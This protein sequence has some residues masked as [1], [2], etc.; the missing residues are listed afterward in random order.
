[1]AFV[2]K[3]KYMGVWIHKNLRWDTHIYGITTK[4]YN[5]FGLAKHTL[6]NAP[7]KVKLV[8]YKT[9]CRPFVEY[10]CEAWDPH[11]KKLTEHLELFQ[12]ELNMNDKSKG[13]NRS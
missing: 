9:L 10:A 2:E 1:M 11:T 6:Y 7:I 5:V 13:R 12:N 4:A 8:A 3:A